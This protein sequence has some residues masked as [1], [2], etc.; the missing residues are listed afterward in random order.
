MTRENKDKIYYERLEELNKKYLPDPVDRC[1]NPDWKKQWETFLKYRGDWDFDFI[2]A[3]LLY[4]LELTK[5]NIDV[6]GSTIRSK[7]RQLMKQIDKAISLADVFYTKDFYEESNNFS[8]EHF[9]NCLIFYKRGEGITP[10]KE[11]ARVWTGS[12][13]FFLWDIDVFGTGEKKEK[14]TKILL[15]NNLSTEFLD[16]KKYTTAFSGDWDSEENAKIS[17]E[18]FKKAEKDKQKAL[19][20]F[21]LYISHHIQGWW[22]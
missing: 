4:K 19:D 13:S 20:K 11:V 15:E 17:V 1:H 9:N 21:F 8:K 22:D 5:L 12:E 6:Y 18:L 10:E 3:T 14:L 7:R 2:I 16:T